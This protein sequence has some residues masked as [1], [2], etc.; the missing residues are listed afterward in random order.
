MISLKLLKISSSFNTSKKKNNLY[1]YPKTQWK[2]YK[3]FSLKIKYYILDFKK[4]RNNNLFCQ[5]VSKY[6]N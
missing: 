3:K 2:I 1:N 6:E 5:N 4:D